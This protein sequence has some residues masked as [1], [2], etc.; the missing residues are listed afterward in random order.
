[1]LCHRFEFHNISFIRVHVFE[2]SHNLARN[3][4]LTIQAEVSPIGT[5]VLWFWNR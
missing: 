2:V 4:F 5:L 1:L 3:F